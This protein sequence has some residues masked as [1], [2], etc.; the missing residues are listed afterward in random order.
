M[1]NDI[2]KIASAIKQAIT[3]YKQS[4]G[5][6]ENGFSVDVWHDCSEYRA[7][8]GFCEDSSMTIMYQID[9]DNETVK[10]LFDERNDD[11]IERIA[12]LML[13]EKWVTIA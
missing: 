7:R 1:I 11:E 2:E 13:S 12:S 6:N 9:T 3:K 10:S 4:G 8:V 5:L